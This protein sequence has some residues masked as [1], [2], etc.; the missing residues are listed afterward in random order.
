M[1][2]TCDTCTKLGPD[3]CFVLKE[4]IGREGECWAWSDDEAWKIFLVNEVKTNAGDSH[5]A[6]VLAL[7]QAGCSLREIAR[8]VGISKSA[9]SWRLKKGGMR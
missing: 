5:M 8:R 9:V 6:E 1:K 3:G 4:M 2:R 7:R